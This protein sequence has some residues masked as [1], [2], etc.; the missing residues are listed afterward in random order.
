MDLRD[1]NNIKPPSVIYIPDIKVEDIKDD[2]T[3]DDN[4]SDTE[5]HLNDDEEYE[6]DFIV[7]DNEVEYESDIETKSESEY[8]FESEV[9]D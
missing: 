9:D 7:D 8:E 6:S 2:I 4:E 3:V 5:S 1:R